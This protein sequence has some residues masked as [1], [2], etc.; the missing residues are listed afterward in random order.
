VNAQRDDLDVLFAEHFAAHRKEQAPDVMP[1]DDDRP[2]PGDEHEPDSEGAR[3]PGDDSDVIGEG[4]DRRSGSGD[5]QN[6][7][8]I[9]LLDGAAIAAPL[10]DLEYLVREI[11]LV[12][13]GGAPHLVAGYGFSGK[14]LALQSLALSLAAGL[15]AWGAYA[16]R[17]PR[18]V[19]HVDLEQ[20]T[21]LTCRRYQRLARAMGVDLAT[22]GDA[23]AVAVMPPWLALTEACAARWHELMIGRD[24]IIIDSLKAAT[25]GRDENDSSIRAGLD[26]LGHVSEQT[27]CRPLPIHHAKKPQADDPGG[28]YAIRGSSG[29]YD[30][31]DSVYLF[32]AAKGEPVSV[33]HVKARSHG[34]LVDSFALVIADAEIDGDARGGLKVDLRGAELVAQRR[35]VRAEAARNALVQRDAE[36]VRKAIGR[37]PGAGTTALRGATG[38]SGVRFAAAVTLLGD[39]IEVREEKRGRSRSTLCHYLRGVQ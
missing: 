21:R 24:L 34:E 27:G 7:Q 20:G 4:A 3:E 18:R 28:R 9:T 33:E 36:V 35:A 16:C 30:A 32:S 5:K 38:L 17:N 6:S 22:L 39:A 31:C 13:G 1:P 26:M 19:L 11:G 29:I 25:A 14:T 8:A 23:L 12:A 37:T 10:P 15:P 2:W